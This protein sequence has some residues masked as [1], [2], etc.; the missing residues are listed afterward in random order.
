MKNNL[1]SEIRSLLNGDTT[2]QEIAIVDTYGCPPG[3]YRHNGKIIS[4]SELED[5]KKDFNNTV[6]FKLARIKY[7]H[8]QTNEN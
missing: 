7:D 4:A 5:L 8:D 2:K 1:K 6:I 3:Y